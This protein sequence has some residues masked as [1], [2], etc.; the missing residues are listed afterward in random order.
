MTVLNDEYL[1]VRS[2]HGSSTTPALVRS[3]PTSKGHRVNRNMNQTGAHGSDCNDY[4]DVKKLELQAE[5]LKSQV[6]LQ[7]ARNESREQDL[8][9]EAAA[10][11]HQHSARSA[12]GYHT[13]HQGPGDSRYNEFDYY[14]HQGQR[15]KLLEY[16]RS[17]NDVSRTGRAG[18]PV[19][20]RCDC[21]DC[22]RD[23]TGMHNRCS[24]VRDQGIANTPSQ[25]QH[26]DPP[27][28]RPVIFQAEARTRY[29]GIGTMT[30]RGI[31][32]FI[33]G[34]DRRHLWTSGDSTLVTWHCHIC[35]QSGL[36]LEA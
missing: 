12:R 23:A 27:P 24:R 4:L 25:H 33:F 30:G 13:D 20:Y 1:T 31:D 36:C 7:K 35:L 26:T 22:R 5:I 19:Y 16:H 6:K 32:T 9:M 17:P 29:L 18:S 11:R 34:R 28:Q 2:R 8:M 21:D 10:S 15:P 14:T 3:R